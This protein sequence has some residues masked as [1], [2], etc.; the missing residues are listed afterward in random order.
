MN[1]FCLIVGCVHTTTYFIQAKSVPMWT[2]WHSLIISQQVLFLNIEYSHGQ[3]YWHACIDRKQC[4]LTGLPLPLSSDQVKTCP[5][6]C[7]EPARNWTSTS[8]LTLPCW[9]RPT[10][11]CAPYR[12]CPSPTG[13]IS[14]FGTVGQH[15]PACKRRPWA[16]WG[17]YMYK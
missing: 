12:E 10:F 17:M 14:L 2:W 11:L 8:S 3:K 5:S 16:Y 7:M 13:V 1:D 6:A 4:L 15:G 9:G